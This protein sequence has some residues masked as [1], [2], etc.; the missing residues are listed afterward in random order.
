[1]SRRSCC[2]MFAAALAVAAPD[3]ARAQQQHQHDGVC[4]TTGACCQ[5]PTATC[6][7]PRNPPAGLVQA[8]RPEPPVRKTM[9]VW[10]HRPVKIGD[11]ILL[12]Q[13][14]IEHDDLRMA[15][16]WPCTYIYEASDQ[17]LP[18]VA[19]RCTHLNRS[20]VHQSTVALRALG[21]ANGMTE[22]TEFQFA[23]ETAAHGV[24]KGR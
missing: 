22:F 21:E 9:T 1:M 7:T 3:V 17:R 4:C 8:P 23:G 16:G 15:R 19:F 11:R 18:V 12:G 5:T 20:R 24:P 13:Y 10:F 14:L 2:F 6:C